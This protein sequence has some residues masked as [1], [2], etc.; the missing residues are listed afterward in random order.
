[1]PQ[2][3]HALTLHLH[4]PPNNLQLLIETNPKEAEQIIHCYDRITRFAHKYINIAHFHIAFSGLLLQQLQQ[5]KIIEQYRQY[6]DIPAMLESYRLAKN[7]ELLGMGMYHP[8]FPLIAPADWEAQLQLERDLMLE[9][10]GRAPRGFLPPEMAFSMQM[11]P[12]LVRAGYEYVLIDAS[13]IRPE[14][15]SVDIFQPYIAQYQD[16]RITVIPMSRDIS[17]AQQTGLDP[18]WFAQEVQHQVWHSARPD[19]P[20]LLSTWSNGENKRW[21]RLEEE[22]FFGHFI[23]PYVEHAENGE[24]PVLPVSIGEYLKQQPAEMRAN[25]EAGAWNMGSTSGYGLADWGGSD[26][27]RKAIVKMRDVR[28]R[29]EKLSQIQ[30]SKTDQTKL[31]QIRQQILISQSSCFIFWGDEWIQ[32]LFDFLQVSEQQ[33]SELETIYFKPTASTRAKSAK[34]VATPQPLVLPKKTEPS[35]SSSNQPLRPSHKVSNHLENKTAVAT[36][37]TA[38]EPFSVKDSTKL[39]A[40]SLHQP[41]RPTADLKP[42]AKPIEKVEATP[43]PAMKR[44]SAQTKP[45]AATKPLS[46]T[47]SKTTARSKTSSAVSKPALKPSAIVESQPVEK[48]ESKAVKTESNTDTKP[49]AA[50][51]RTTTARTT[52]TSTGDS[53]K[54]TIEEAK[55]IPPKPTRRKTTARKTTKKTS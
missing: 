42:S 1:M 17:S 32:K 22:G 10:F 53:V 44:S 25:I 2:I 45:K 34:P 46:K 55:P 16:A 48:S 15:E 29:Y 41:I 40:K 19:A 14:H 43:K 9:L 24:Y 11:I 37:A 6:I 4:Q 36:Q 20:R 26:A 23:A 33:L 31:A 52:T 21:F 50:K 54:A 51:P 7:I 5:P 8:I 28:Q 27:Q 12:A 18:V 47:T 49:V 13:S 39:A 35:A 3:F 38:V 30:I